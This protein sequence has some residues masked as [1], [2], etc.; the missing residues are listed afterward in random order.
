M[1]TLINHQG[2]KTITGIQ[3]QTPSPPIG[4]AYLGGFLK[5]NG[6]DYHGID[7]CGENLDQIFPYPKKENVMVQ[8]LTP[9]QIRERIPKKTTIFGFTCL[10]SHCWPLVLDIAKIAK[11]ICPH[12][13][14]VAGGE[15][16]TALPEQVLKSGLFDAVVSGEGEETFLE[17]VN[18]VKSKQ[19]WRS[20][21]GIIHLNADNILIRNKPRAR[22]TNIDEFPY[23]DWDTWSIKSY[24]DQHQVSGI[25]IGSSMP[26]L[27]S[28]GC[29]YECTFC[30]NPDMW[31]RRYIMRDP[32]SLVDEMEYMKSK[33]GVNGFT[34]MDSTFVV[35]RKKT[36]DFCHELINRGLN[37][38]YQLPAGTRS[39]AFD[40]E[41]AFALDHSGL[42]NFAFA[43]ESGD[44]EIL[45]AI[46]KQVNLDKLLEAARIVLKTRMTVGC[47]I[48]I[49]FPED[50][51]RSM[52][53]TLTLIRKLALMGVHDVTVSKFTPYPGSRYFNDFVKQGVIS[54]NMTELSNIID[55]YSDEGKSF[56]PA[57][58]FKQLYIWMIWMFLNFYVISFTVRPWRV[59]KNFWLFFTKNQESARYMRFF[60]EI[61][62]LRK[63]WKKPTKDMAVT[64]LKTP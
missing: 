62:Y 21:D 18:K 20:I 11:E 29:P 12:A 54:N 37:I 8:G 30:S 7:A 28:R 51:H 22:I 9:D 1:I 6:H 53:S 36:L 50:T 13:F 34:F 3:I 44:V 19:D 16:P 41:L 14:F 33:Y 27:G 24:I 58:S 5:K 26:I 49:G 17:L 42:R 38:G 55:F 35:N 32:K 46:K 52:R 60:T 63:K 47:F 48:V 15:H 39:E 40:E 59:V 31:T 56:C 45:K 43:P 25:N 61:F 10:F 64:S 57:I 4:L 2:L 23:P